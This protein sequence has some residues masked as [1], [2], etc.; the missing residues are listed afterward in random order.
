MSPVRVNLTVF[1]TC[2][3]PSRRVPSSPLRPALPGYC[4]AGL[5]PS[6]DR[7]AGSSC[8]PGGCLRDVLAVS[9]VIAPVLRHALMQFGPTGRRSSRIEPPVVTARGPT[10]R[11]RRALLM[12]PA[13]RPPTSTRVVGSTEIQVVRGLGASLSAVNN[14]LRAL[15]DRAVFLQE[16]DGFL[17]N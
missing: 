14:R 15:C 9:P 2:G 17:Y 4:R 11:L 13:A 10:A 6:A 16:M 8:S 7:R 12:S 3:T 1:L 5:F